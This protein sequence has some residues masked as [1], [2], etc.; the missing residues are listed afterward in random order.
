MKRISTLLTILLFLSVSKTF[1]QQCTILGCADS[2]GPIT[3]DNTLPLASLGLGTGCYASGGYKQ[4]FWEFFQSQSGGDFI[5]SITETGGV[6]VDWSMYDLGTTAPTQTCPFNV[7]TLTPL[8]CN[9]SSFNPTGPGAQN[10]P[11]RTVTGHYYALAIIF[12]GGTTGS[13]TLGRPS[14]VGYTYL[15]CA[16]NKGTITINGPAHSLQDGGLGTCS[17]GGLGN[18]VTPPSPPA[19]GAGAYKQVFWQFF[20]VPAGGGGGNNVPYTQAFTPTDST[21]VDLDLD[22]VVFDL[23]TTAPAANPFFCPT[24]N[25][26]FVNPL[27][28][29]VSSNGGHTTGP[30]T[31][32]S[33]TL[34]LTKKHY[35]AIGVFYY[36]NISTSFTIRDP[37]INGLPLTAANCAIGVLPV[38]LSSFD[39]KTNGCSVELSWT[40]ETETNFSDYEVQYS[41]DGSSFQTIGTVVPSDIKNYSYQHANPAQGKIYYRLR[42]VD[43]DGSFEY[44]KVI[45]LNL[46]CNRAEVVV[47]PNPVTD[48][49]NINITN[50]QSE[51]I[52]NLYDNTGKLVFTGNMTNGTNSIDMTKFTSGMYLLVLKN[53]FETQNLKIIKQ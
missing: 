31:S 45:A 4:V 34:T 7:S 43:L 18:T 13:F 14:Y 42:M 1:S 22:W 35:Y 50:A 24:G 32:G 53:N 25:T 30:G 11:I 2:Y 49:V 33:P 29:D 44:S 38:T 10:D 12:P 23:G 20:F 48:K 36:Q 26:T 8:E 17:G 3:V 37:L 9:I 21:T 51:T 19:F 47:Y 28:C 41:T 5:Q 15:G 52:A 6:D 46:N 27:V 16:A 40:A 39:A